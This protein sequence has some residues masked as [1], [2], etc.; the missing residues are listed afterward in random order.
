MSTSV[1]RSAVGKV[2][3]VI[4]GLETLSSYIATRLVLLLLLLVLVVGGD[5]FKKA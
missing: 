3:C 1:S 5:L 4:S 2:L